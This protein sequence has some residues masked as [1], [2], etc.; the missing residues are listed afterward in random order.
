MVQNDSGVTS[1]AKPLAQMRSKHGM[2]T[3]AGCRERDAKSL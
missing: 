3:S 2:V 1:K